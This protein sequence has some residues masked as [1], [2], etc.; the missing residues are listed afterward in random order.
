MKSGSCSL[1][2]AAQGAVLKDRRRS[3]TRKDI[4]GCMQ[5]QSKRRSLR[6]MCVIGWGYTVKLREEKMDLV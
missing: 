4:T 2:A 6:D 3:A 1:T 5:V